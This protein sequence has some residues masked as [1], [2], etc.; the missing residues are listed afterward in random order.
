MILDLKTL[1]LTISA[2]PCA[3]LG[4]ARMTGAAA[5]TLAVGALEIW[6]RIPVRPVLNQLFVRMNTSSTRAV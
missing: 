2:M 4:W 1:Q 3:R 5:L 6:L